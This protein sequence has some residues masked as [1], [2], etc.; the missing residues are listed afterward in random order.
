[1]RGIRRA[2]MKILVLVPL[3]IFASVVAIGPGQLVSYTPA[4]R[5]G[6]HSVIAFWISIPTALGVL[7]FQEKR[8]QTN[9]WLMSALSFPMVVHIG[10]AALNLFRDPE[11]LIIRALP[12][13]V[14]DMFE[15]ALLSTLL[16]GACVS[17]GRDSDNQ[18]QKIP[19]LLLTP[20][21][22]LIPLTIFGGIWILVLPL[23]TFESLIALS[24]LF[25][26]IAVSG[27]LVSSVFV[28]RFRD[29]E[30][31]IDAGFFVS[32]TLL[33]AASG[34]ALMLTAFTPLLNWE[35][36]ETLQ[37]ASY[38]LLALALGVPFLKRAGFRRRTA[39]GI[40]IGL[41]L[42]AYLPF[43]IT[44]VI[45][46][47][48]LPLEIPP[49]L[50]AYS[51][52][53]IGAASLSAMMAILLYIYPK[54]KTSWNQYPLIYV[55]GMWCGIAIIQVFLLL[56][57]SIAPLGEPITPYNV[58][59]LLTFGLLYLFV[60]WTKHP[61]IDREET[62]SLFRLALGLTGLITAIIAGE[63][64]NQLVLISNPSLS[65]NPA[66]NTLILVTNL[67]IMFAFA[68]IIFLLSED[69][70]GEAPVELYVILFLAM[71]ILPNILKSYYTIWTAGWWVSE[72]LLFIGLLSGPLVFTWLYVRTMHEVEESHRRANMY[73]D[74]LMHDV[75][76]YN[77][78][79][80]MSMELL[81]SHEIPEEQRTRLADDGRQVI[82]FSEQLISNVRL[83]S[84]AEQLKTTELQPTNLVHTIV[85]ALDLFTRRIGTGELIVEFQ[86]EESQAS[87][88]ANDL[89]AH[90]FL[91]ILYSALECRIRGETVTIGLHETE[92]SGENFW[93]IDIKAPG[94]SEEQEEGF[95]SG[96]LGLLAA[97]LMTESLNGY[98]EMETFA[99][100]DICE[101]RLFSIKLR[102]TND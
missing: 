98:F 82:S 10:S 60:I 80:M 30:P 12:D 67:F 44:I 81:G 27:F 51:I 52:I 34:I 13:T 25:G 100:T 92:Y 71:W 45:E 91:N 41:I 77:Q 76:N 73:A 64:I 99:R 22:L 26:I 97:R 57:P 74:L 85:G 54:N 88:M 75:S 83:L 3:A 46:S 14:S 28:L 66:S 20:I 47:S 78:M 62:P 93:Q 95:S 18:E 11:S 7:A 63:A 101:G 35:F 61:P 49:N 53:H 50:L 4:A 94:R 68:Y 39:Y 8:S 48:P 31:P 17:I 38:L 79:M 102:A 1:M 33:F 58:V 59:S 5:V 42:M 55:F 16:A 86:A 24:S 19:A 2:L 9:L 72:F 90:I 43:L 21:L 6:V 36:A 65:G 96:T 56:F 23:L 87:V 32:S 70:N 89:L 40:I 15:L 37:M 69:S 29:T 84:E